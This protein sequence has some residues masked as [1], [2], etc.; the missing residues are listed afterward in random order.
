ML[1]TMG[2]TPPSLDDDQRIELF[3]LTREADSVELKMTVDVDAQRSA[4]A[5][6]GIDPLGARLRL[7]H[8]FDTP[9]LA[10]EASGL[11][12]RARR[13]QG[14]EDDSVVKLRP[15]V[16][17]ELP[18][19]VRDSGDFVVEVDAM[20]GGFVCSGSLKGRPRS[21]GVQEVI[22][23]GQPLRRLFSKSQRAF[24]AAHAPD[25]L[26]LDDL[27]LLGPVF[28][29]KLKSSPKGFSRRLAVE[30][31]L[32]PDG[33]RVLELST[34]CATTEAFDAAA[35]TRAYLFKRGV[36]AG[37]EQQTKTRKALEL[38]SQGLR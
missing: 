27:S 21:S 7:I 9:D 12:V 19:D 2:A 26:A 34:R 11:V 22:G 24:F 37:A 29:L 33:S 1:A 4:I 18:A 28:V 13:I 32:F 5:A 31:W 23:K 8:F 35:E 10:L 25:D 16:P 3:D 14:R 30:L 20:P 6:L 15:V 38:F 17:H 36:E